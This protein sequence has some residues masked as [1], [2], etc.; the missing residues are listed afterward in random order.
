MGIPMKVGPNLTLTFT[1]KSTTILS[2]PGP[3]SSPLISP[4]NATHPPWEL[5]SYHQ[6]L[7]LD[8]KESVTVMAL[9]VLMA[10]VK[11]SDLSNPEA[12][13]LLK[14]KERGIK[15]QVKKR[16][17][18]WVAGGGEVWTDGEQVMMD[19]TVT[20]TAPLPYTILLGTH[21]FT[22]VWLRAVFM[23]QQTHSNNPM[24]TTSY[25]STTSLWLGVVKKV[26]IWG[27]MFG[28]CDP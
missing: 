8:V 1:K 28:N 15:N 6:P 5:T 19:L 21:T 24:D 13:P 23:W 10:G 14:N 27:S 20:L 16:T 11:M 17:A 12:N 2:S 22:F 3:P 25:I 26:K 7:W 4:Y 9:W 18:C